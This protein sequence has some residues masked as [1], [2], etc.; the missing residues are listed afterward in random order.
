M[1]CGCLLVSLWE[2]RLFFTLYSKCV[3]VLQVLAFYSLYEQCEQ[4][5]D[6]SENWL[7]V[8]APPASEPEPLKVQLDRCQVSETKSLWVQTFLRTI[9][10][11]LFID[12]TNCHV[13]DVHSFLFSMKTHL[14]KALF[15]TVLSLS[16][17]ILM[18]IFKSICFSFSFLFQFIFFLNSLLLAPLYVYLLELFEILSLFMHLFVTALFC[19]YFFVCSLQSRLNEMSSLPYFLICPLK[20]LQPSLPKMMLQRKTQSLIWCHFCLKL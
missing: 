5:V 11:Y 4:T 17:L 10:C 2:L 19:K 9:H 20:S 3:R 8:Q 12:I 15:D 16:H 7:K 1:L 14:N 6:N 18:Y 13:L